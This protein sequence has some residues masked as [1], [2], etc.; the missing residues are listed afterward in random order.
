M[1]EAGR[2]VEADGG[3]GQKV[4]I[5]AGAITHTLVEGQTLCFFYLLSSCNTVEIKKK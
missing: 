3:G 2:E 1:R 5:S 4:L